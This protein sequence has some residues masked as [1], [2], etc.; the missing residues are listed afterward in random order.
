[1]FH[2]K[3][4]SA[5]GC[6]DSIRFTLGASSPGIMS[7]TNSTY[8]CPG[9]SIGNAIVSLTPALGSP[10]GQISFSASSIGSLTP[11]FSASLAVGFQNTLALTNLSAGNYSVFGF[12]GSCKY[13]NTFSIVNFP[14]NFT[15]TPNS[16][17][18]CTGQAVFAG[19]TFTSPPSP[20]QY[21]Y[22]WSPNVFIPGNTQ[23]STIIFPSLSPGTFTSIIYTVVVTPSVINCPISKTLS[24]VAGHPLPPAINPIPILCQNSAG[25]TINANPSGGTFSSSLFNG[26]FPVGPSSGIISTS[27]APIGINTFSYSAGIGTCVASSTSTYEISGPS[28]TVSPFINLC[29]NQTAT[30][31]AGGANSYT[32]SNGSFNYSTAVSPTI[33]TTYSV[34]GSTSNNTCTSIQTVTVNLLALPT[35]S[36]SGNQNI[37]NFQSA[38]LTAS[39][40]ASYLW[41]NG[42]ASATCVVQP[43]TS[44]VFTVFGASALGCVNSNTFLVNVNYGPLLQVKGNTLV[45]KGEPVTLIALGANSYTWAWNQGSNNPTLTMIPSTT[46]IYTLS[47]LSYTNPCTSQ[48]QHTVFVEEC[49]GDMEA[50]QVPFEIRI[51]PNPSSGLFFIKSAEDLEIEVFNSLGQIV[52]YKKIFS[53]KQSIDL[54]EQAAGLYF[55]NCKTNGISQVVRLV[56]L[57]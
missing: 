16:V 22:S 37:C 20:G 23:S 47:G 45:C 1:L 41:N 44:S 24:L 27:L 39:G 35:I 56:K 46:I 14:D 13:T 10:P 42:I 32:W 53:G 4:L 2:L 34:I 26:Q 29:T 33:T 54:S 8:T 9:A 48:I 52:L 31:Q 38:T 7:I 11:N 43:S 12:D 55:M 49:V 30:I 28:L 15:L 57:D 51:Y 21:T 25:Y 17:T 50:K 40:A 36:V 3:Y 19:I 5:Q 6:Q 18:L